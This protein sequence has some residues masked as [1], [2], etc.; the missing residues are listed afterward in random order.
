MLNII[1][2]E[3]QTWESDLFALFKALSSTYFDSGH[4]EFEIRNSNAWLQIEKIVLR[5]TVES[6]L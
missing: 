1:H 5:G 3:P 2:V 6:E 4:W